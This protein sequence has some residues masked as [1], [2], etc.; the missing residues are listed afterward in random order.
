MKWLIIKLKNPIK[1]C[2]SDCVNCFTLMLSGCSKHC[3]LSQTFLVMNFV[4]I[5][6]I[7]ITGSVSLQDMPFLRHSGWIILGLQTLVWC[8]PDPN[9]WLY[10]LIILYQL[11][12]Q[13]CLLTRH[14]TELPIF[15]TLPPKID[16]DM[17]RKN[18]QSLSRVRLDENWIVLTCWS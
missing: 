13:K 14:P 11:Y 17:K 12:L 4:K 15:L 10:S 1:T 9:C 5:H 2:A 3:K 16:L 6:Y 8:N 7:A 18:M